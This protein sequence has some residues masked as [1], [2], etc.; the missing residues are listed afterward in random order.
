MTQGKL[1]PLGVERWAQRRQERDITNS[2]YFKYSYI[3]HI[4]INSV[5]YIL[6]VC[7]NNTLQISLHDSLAVSWLNCNM[8]NELACMQTKTKIEEKKTEFY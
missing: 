5:K 2:A 8:K 6:T 4:L 3:S 1:L 7:R